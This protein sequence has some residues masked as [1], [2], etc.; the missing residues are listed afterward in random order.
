MTRVI[1]LDTGGTYTDAALVDTDGGRVVATGKALTTRDDLSI[2]VGGAICRILDNY[3]GDASDM[4][5]R[6]ASCALSVSKPGRYGIIVGGETTVKLDA[7][8]GIGGRAQEVALTTAIAFAADAKSAPAN[9]AVLV[10]GTDG[11]DGPCDAAGAIL[12]SDDALDISKAKAALKA[13]D[14]Y[15]FLH[16]A[17]QLL[18]TGG[19]GTNLGDL[20][21]ILFER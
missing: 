2:G 11:R 6:L 12:T 21:I 19:T 5:A 17:G 9:W 14:C 7:N 18:M 15:P 16:Q 10:G 1:G 13:H 8:S 4:G 3:D 20:A